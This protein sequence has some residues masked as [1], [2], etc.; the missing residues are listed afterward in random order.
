[1]VTP[2]QRRQCAL[3][4]NLTAASTST[5]AGWLAA[6]ADSAAAAAGS[7]ATAENVTIME[8]IPNNSILMFDRFFIAFSNSDNVKKFHWPDWQKSLLQDTSV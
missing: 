7:A 8:I 5:A 4:A 1:L 3:R 6:A 2:W